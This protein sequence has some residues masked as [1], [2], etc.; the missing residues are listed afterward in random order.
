MRDVSQR[1]IERQDQDN[2]DEME[3]WGSWSVGKD[4]LEQCNE[5]V[6]P[7]FRNLSM[8][9]TLYSG[10]CTLTSRHWLS[11]LPNHVPLYSRAQ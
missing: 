10:R 5:R 4:D 2:K 7:V 1:E 3:D 9:A 11:E 6:Q 8:L